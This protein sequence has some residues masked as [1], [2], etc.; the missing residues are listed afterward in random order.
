MSM[1]G[2]V[3]VEKRFGG[4]LRWCEAAAAA[5]R[6]PACAAA[7]PAALAAACA[8]ADPAAAPA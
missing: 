7:E 1:Q 6:R 2:L 8:A 5:A 4:S 3:V